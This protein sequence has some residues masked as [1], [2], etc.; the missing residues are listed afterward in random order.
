ML[1]TI[2]SIRFEKGDR[3]THCVPRGTWDPP[4]PRLTRVLRN[5]LDFINFQGDMKTI[6][7]SSAA[8]GEGKVDCSA[9]LA[10][11]LANAGKKVVLVSSDFR[12]STTQEFF[13]VNNFIGLS[14][15]LLGAHSLKAAL[16]RPA[17]L[18][19]WS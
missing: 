12:R 7:V 1:G 4:L 19:F 18:S 10:A 6:V 8:P 5:S 15:V 17:T 14:D 3:Q 2:P 11:A 9:N 13:K 16:Q